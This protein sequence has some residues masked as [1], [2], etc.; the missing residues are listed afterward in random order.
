MG[1]LKARCL[2]SPPNLVPRFPL[3]LNLFSFGCCD[4]SFPLSIWG[5][6]V[7]ASPTITIVVD[8]LASSSSAAAL[9]P[10]PPPF[11]VRTC[12]IFTP[13][14]GLILLTACL[15]SHL[16]ITD[17]LPLTLDHLVCYLIVFQRC[18]ALHFHFFCS[19]FD[20]GALAYLP[21]P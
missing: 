17:N 9:L 4:F 14:F 3:Y 6:S 15:H 20:K 18:R 16:K 2:Q 12:S 8:H 11:L 7:V 19:L 13:Q 21:K 1:F 10:F 5:A